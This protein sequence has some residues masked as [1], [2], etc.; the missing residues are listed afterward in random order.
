MGEARQGLEHRRYDPYPL[1]LRVLHCKGAAL[2]QHTALSIADPGRAFKGAYQALL[3]K[4][5]GW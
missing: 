2:R 4:T 3:M 1:V 5:R